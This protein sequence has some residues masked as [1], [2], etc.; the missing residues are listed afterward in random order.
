MPV[1]VSGISG[2][3]VGSGSGVGVRF[4]SG[5]VDAAVGSWVRAAVAE[6]GVSVGL[7]SCDD[8]GRGGWGVGGVSDGGGVL[9]PFI[10]GIRQFS[11]RPNLG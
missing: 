3:G 9:F 11:L 1:G 5:S 6:I 2:V 7:N 4:G 10:A 8:P